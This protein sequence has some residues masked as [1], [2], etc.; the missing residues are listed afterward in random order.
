MFIEAI[1][2]LQLRGF[3]PSRSEAVRHAIFEFLKRELDLICRL[4][5]LTENDG[6]DK[7]EKPEEKI[8]VTTEEKHPS[9]APGAI[10]LCRS[11]TSRTINSVD[12]R[13]IKVAPG[14]FAKVDMRAIKAGDDLS[15][16][17]I[18]GIKRKLGIPD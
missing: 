15:D 1:A 10:A 17:Q 12:T 11:F 3:F 16:V 9:I 4:L 13:A 2:E 18:A 5:L 8:Q 6:K 14:A 7:G